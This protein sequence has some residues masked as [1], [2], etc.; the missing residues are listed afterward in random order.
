VTVALPAADGVN[1]TAH[2]ATPAVP[3]ATSVHGDVTN[4]PVTP[5]TAN[6]TE[7]VGVPAPALPVTFAVQDD[8]TPTVVDAGAHT[9]PVDVAF[10][11]TVNVFDALLAA[12]TAL[13][14]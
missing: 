1:D 14:A 3:V 13:P 7:P 10:T 2:D 12:S 11:A 6:E 4:D 8:A 9:T 5:V